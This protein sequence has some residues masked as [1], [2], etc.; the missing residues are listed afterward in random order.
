MSL[1]DVGA[2]GL[3]VQLLIRRRSGVDAC[4]AAFRRWSSRTAVAIAVRVF[5]NLGVIYIMS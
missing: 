5:A 1:S 4:S 2:Q 3:E